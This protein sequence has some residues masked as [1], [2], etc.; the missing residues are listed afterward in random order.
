MNRHFV[1]IPGKEWVNQRNCFSDSLLAAVW[2]VLSSLLKIVVQLE[3]QKFI[4]FMAKIY[5]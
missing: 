4:L 3:S 2:E 5:P 1:H